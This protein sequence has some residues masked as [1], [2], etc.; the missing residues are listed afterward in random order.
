MRKF[1][2]ISLFIRELLQKRL[3]RSRLRHPPT[4]HCEPKPGGGIAFLESRGFVAKLGRPES[5]APRSAQE[6]HELV[7]HGVISEDAFRGMVF[8]N[9]VEFWTSGNRDFFS[10]TAVKRPRTRLKS[11]PRL[12][13]TCRPL[14]RV[15]RGVE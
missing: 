2:V 11:R 15:R 5:W 4:S 1:P 6:A 8:T 12:R 9:A 3:V 7:E 10:G 14:D 13:S